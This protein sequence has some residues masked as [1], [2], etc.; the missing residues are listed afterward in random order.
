MPIPLINQPWI[1]APFFLHWGFEAPAAATFFF[2]P[3]SQLPGASP[4]TKLILRSYGGL[5]FA[6][7]LL[8]IAFLTRPKYDDATITF[9]AM[10]AFY[11]IFPIYRAVVRIRRG[12]GV[13][14]TQGRVLGGPSLHLV[15]H[16]IS[17][18]SLAGAAVVAI[19]YPEQRR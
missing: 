5:L 18:V 1:R 6:T 3:S 19:K 7:C 14:G 8:S 12:L 9:G 13:E 4:E 2:A 10:M 11:H 17:F 16:L 15:V